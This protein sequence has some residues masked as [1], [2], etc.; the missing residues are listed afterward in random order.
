MAGKKDVS[1]ALVQSVYTSAGA[2][3][4]STSVR[5]YTGRG[6]AGVSRTG[7]TS[8]LP[9]GV[10]ARSSYPSAPTHVTAYQGGPAASGVHTN[11]PWVESSGA[12]SESTA[13]PKT[14]PLSDES[15]RSHQLESAGPPIRVAVSR[16]AAIRIFENDR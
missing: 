7:S 4:G 15:R 1:R 16:S 13:N 12:A 2:P 11:N 5:W 10:M 6:G 14:V 9:P 8:E 3:N